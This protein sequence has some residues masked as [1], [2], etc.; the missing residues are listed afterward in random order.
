MNKS[1]LYQQ[2]LVEYNRKGILTINSQPAV[3]GKPST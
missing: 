1:Q 2:L 3:N